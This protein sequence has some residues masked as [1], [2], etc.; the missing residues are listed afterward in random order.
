MNIDLLIM[1]SSRPE[2]L[3]YTYESFQ[4]YIE[5]LCEAEIRVLFHEDCVYP[6]TSKISKRYG[7]LNGFETFS[8]DPKI[9]L[10]PAMDKMFKKVKTDY[11][12]YLQDDFEFER[13][14]DLDRILW[15]MER[16]ARVNCITFNKR[17]IR[18]DTHEYVFDGLKLYI[19]KFWSF[20]PGIWRMSVVRK[21]WIGPV[22]I[23]PESRWFKTNVGVSYVYDS[24][25]EYRYVRHLG[26]TWRMAD[27]VMK[28][29]IPGRTKNPDA[30]EGRAPWLGPPQ[31]R[32][33]G[34]RDAKK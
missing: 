17:K 22:E 30:H 21:H 2:L 8:H 6:N 9:G 19:R 15:T 24:P 20:N 3:R 11:M 33:V 26:D 18:T 1:G 27:W 31:K 14:I 16:N 13:P 5:D 25:G 34:E 28:D 29:N 12:F 7:K 32:P 10:G 23:K 4:K